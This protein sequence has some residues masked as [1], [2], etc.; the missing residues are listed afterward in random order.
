MDYQ[1]HRDFIST[2]SG[3][4]SK[5]WRTAKAKLISQGRFDQAMKMDIDEIRT[6]YGT[7]YDNAIQQ[8]VAHMPKNRSFQTFLK[9]NGW[10]I[11]YSLLK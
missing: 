6:Q 1:D 7:K 5:D 3:Q 8:M 2:G 11:N 9:K 10:T 4:D